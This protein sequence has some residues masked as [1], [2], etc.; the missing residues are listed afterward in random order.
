MDALSSGIDIPISPDTLYPRLGMLS[1]PSLLQS[2]SLKSWQILYGAQEQPSESSREDV[3]EALIGV[4]AVDSDWNWYA[5]ESVV[6]R[7]STD[8]S[9]RG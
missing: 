2:F 1:C 5:L 3:M 8:G 6:L 7:S 9:W 4:V